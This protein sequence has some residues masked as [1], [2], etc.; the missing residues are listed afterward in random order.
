[1][2]I[3]LDVRGIYTTQNGT[4]V[5][6]LSEVSNGHIGTMNRTKDGTMVF[7]PHSYYRCMYPG[8]GEVI[9]YNRNGNLISEKP[10]P[11]DKPL[12][13]VRQVSAQ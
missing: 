2:G 7:V 11:N 3:R 4:L 6:V 10:G 8:S 13:V 1:M 9:Y 12:Q 5:M